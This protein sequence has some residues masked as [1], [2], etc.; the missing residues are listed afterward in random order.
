MALTQESVLSFLLE[1]G[2]KVRNSEL[3]G[4][5]GSLIHSGSPAEK[6]HNRELFKKL[7][8]SVA[9][10]RQTDGVKFVAVKKRYQD[11]VKD[12]LHETFLSCSNSTLQLGRSEVENDNNA[13]YWSQRSKSDTTLS[14]ERLR[15]QLD[16]RSSGAV[17]AVVAVTSPAAPQE[18]P[19]SAS[20]PHLPVCNDDRA[21]QSWP[22]S[23]AD[24][25]ECCG[26]V[27]LDPLAHEWLVKCAAGLWGHV[28]AMLLQDVR[29]AQKKDFMSGFTALH[30]AAKD[31]NGEM[32]RKLMEVT[33]RRGAHVN[34]NSKAHGGYTPLHIATIHGH[35]EVMLLLVRRYGA[36]VDE[37]DND[38]KKARHYLG[39]GVSEEVMALVGGGQ[40]SK[41]WCKMDDEDY[42]EQPKG[43]NTI[44]KLFQ[45]HR[46]Q[47]HA[48]RFTHDE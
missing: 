38:G 21:P 16:S 18:K 23:H 43:L 47:K 2:G 35:A 15:D 36:S 37:R 26:S 28:H 3:L 30:W 39:A 44:S 22:S 41:D 8:N 31:G 25:A 24:E 9:V 27:P 10:V 45:P 34:V 17:F 29:L 46:K 32:V 5:F 20:Q 1:R 11:F 40:L 6:Q 14:V 13:R 19:N 7:V 33:R 4:H 12:A 42:Q 48:T